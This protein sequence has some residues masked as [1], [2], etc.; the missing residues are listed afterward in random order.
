MMA[1][2][3][4][5]AVTTLGAQTAF[6]NTG[7]MLSDRQAGPANG[8]KTLDTFD[9]IRIYMKTGIIVAGRDGIIIGD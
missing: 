8:V 3:I 4:L 7:I 9:T 5:A 1:I 6:A 2:L